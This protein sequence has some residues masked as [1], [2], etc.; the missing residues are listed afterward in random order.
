[1]KLFNKLSFIPA[2]LNAMVFCKKT[3]LIVNWEITRRCNSRCQ[4]CNIWS[5]VCEEKTT[6]QVISIIQELSRLGTKMVHFTGGE[7]L[8]REDIGTILDYCADKNILT[9]MNSNGFLVPQQL[10]KIK[11]VC[12][13]TISLDGPEEV[14]DSI[15][16]QGAFGKVIR[17]IVAAKGKG[18][19]VN[20]L[21]VLSR[22]NLE[23]IG[24]LL[25]KSRELDAPLFFQPATELLL[26]SS[27]KNQVTPDI[28]K[29]KLVMKELIRRKKETRYIANSLS[30]LRFLS[31][32]PE[33]PSIRCLVP[34]ISCR[35]QSD[36]SV[37][38]CY[39][40]QDYSVT[41]NG[42]NP[43]FK[44]AFSRLPL[45]HCNRCCCASLVEMNSLLSLKL[46]AILNSWHVF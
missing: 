46:D 16:G 5:N 40:N 34:L 10:D 35:V 1:M 12:L 22:A 44:E 45:I 26:G 13:L 39:R 20:L 31:E 7:P 9:T 23:S 37:N 6:S 43:S 42:Q 32:W 25:E 11:N 14:H 24:F 2:I 4:Y 33:I 29:Y 21:V 15:R 30:G 19:K 36:G 28:G 41:I 18:I 8:L 3:P 17:A 27:A 38:I